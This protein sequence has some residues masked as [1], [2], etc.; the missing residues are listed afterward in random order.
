MALSNPLLSQSPRL[1]AAASNQTPL[2][3]GERGEPVVRLQVALISAGRSL[4]QSTKD[5][6]AVP[7]GIFGPETTAAVSDFQTDG[8]LKLNSTKLT[9][10]LTSNPAELKKLF[11]NVDL[12]T[13]ANNGVAT[14]MQS[15]LGNLSQVKGGGLEKYWSDSARLY[16]QLLKTPP[17]SD[18]QL[19]RA[20]S[21]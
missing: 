9:S 20:W 7:D 14:S 19:A 1:R 5:Q 15:Y 12:T 8:T 3:A 21:R 16:G 17:D 18:R 11:T 13:S 10:A 2:R 6:S 4:P